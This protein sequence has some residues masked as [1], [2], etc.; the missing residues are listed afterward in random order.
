MRCGGAFYDS[1]QGGALA[2]DPA[3][4]KSC[5]T[6]A[7]RSDLKQSS[8]YRACC[9]AICSCLHVLE[10]I[11]SCIIALWQWRNDCTT[12]GSRSRTA[13]ERMGSQPR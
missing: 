9:A 12:P 5:I 4:Q 1:T 3:C 8:L 7:K 2:N 11:R 10:T 13:A 6:C